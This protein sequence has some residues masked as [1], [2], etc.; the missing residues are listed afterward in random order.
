MTIVLNGKEESLA[1]SLTL[2]ELL[3]RRQLDSKKVIAEINGTIIASNL[4]SGTKI[5]SGD[6]IELV[7]LVGGG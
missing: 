5:A 2:E 3:Q 7:R 1:E 6:K 4:F